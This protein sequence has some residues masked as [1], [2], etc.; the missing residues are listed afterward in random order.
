MSDKGF[1]E[2][3][4]PSLRTGVIPVEK[5]GDLKEYC[6]PSDAEIIIKNEPSSINAAME[7]ILDDVP[8]DDPDAQIVVGFDSEWNIE[9]SVGGRVQ[10]CG[11]TSVIQIAYKN[12]VYI[13]QVSLFF[14][15]FHLESILMLGI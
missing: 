11:H 9:V 8:S 1:L 7:T 14:F 6:L 2:K 5:Y 15:L 13:L 3:S 10:E 12:R 4:F